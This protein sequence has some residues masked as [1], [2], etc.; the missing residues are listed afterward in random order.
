[1][2]A[3]ATSERASSTTVSG[4]IGSNDP[5]ALGEEPGAPSVEDVELL[6][7]QLAR[8]RERARDAARD[9]RRAERDALE[10]ARR[11]S[12]V[13]RAWHGEQERVAA[14]LERRSIR[15]ATQLRRRRGA[16][17]RGLARLRRDLSRAPAPPALPVHPPRRLEEE[18]DSRRLATAYRTALLASLDTSNGPRDA[19]RV[20]LIDSPGSDPG[21]GSDAVRAGRLAETLRGLGA[22]VIRTGPPTDGRPLPADT[23]MVIVADPDVDPLTMPPGVIRV[24]WAS[25]DDDP[26][27]T[28]W[29]I[30]LPTD[31]EP[32]DGFADALR[33]WL[34]ATRVAIRT[35]TG[36]L[37]K[38]AVWGDTYFARDLRAAFRAAGHPTR[39]HFYDAWDHPAVGQDDVV[40][41][42]VGVYEPAEPRGAARILWQISHPELATAEL[43]GRYD[44]VFVASDAFSTLMAEESGIAVTPL[45]QATD[46]LRFRPEAAG[47]R[48]PLLF[49]ANWRPNRPIVADL[50]PTHQPLEIHGRGWT[51]EQAGPG[52]TVHDP[53]PNEQLPSYYA[54]ASIV[55]NDHAP[56]MRREGFLGNRLYDAA[57]SGALVISDAVDGLESEFD[58]GVLAYHDGDELRDLIDH[59]LADDAARAGLA[60]RARQAVL[61]RHTFAHRVAV[62][63]DASRPVLD[64]ARAAP[65]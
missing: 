62:L 28:E 11:L 41:D 59:Y 54:G 42:L 24:G 63:L 10:T 8:E 12:K 23:D 15:F 25:A 5:P 34:A 18:P 40:V 6:R 43:Y 32:G 57:A 14:L 51:P 47:P 35:P 38:A 58:G 60:A 31:D 44:R 7:A 16:V 33:T 36:S 30:L 65:S 17:E 3:R 29:D 48:T 53:I 52:A 64:A 26:L 39:I 13:T 50:M 49:V 21:R 37:A 22:H 2:T 45:H 56:G 46:P 55:L 1:M 27:R 4:A 61:Q 20:T 9:A 19:L